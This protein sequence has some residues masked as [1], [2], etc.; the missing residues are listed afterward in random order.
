MS[1]LVEQLADEATMRTQLVA[2]MEHAIHGRYFNALLETN[3]PAAPV[4]DARTRGETEMTSKATFKIDPA[5]LAVLQRSTIT[6]TTVVL[7]EG[8]LDRKLYIAVNKVLEASGGKWM[9]GPKHHAFPSD[10]RKALGLALETGEAVDEQKLFQA[11]YTPPAV[12]QRVVELA[13]LE[14]GNR[15]L[16]PSAGEGALLDAIEWDRLPRGVG[17]ERIWN[18]RSSCAVEM[19]PKAAAVLRTKGY[20]VI[21]ADFLQTKL[22][23]TIGDGAVMDFSIDWRFDRILMNPPFTGGQDVGHV[24]H[25]LKFLKPGGILVSVM[26]AGVGFKTDKKTIAFNKLLDGIDLSW[27]R[28]ECPEGAF[29]ESGTNVRVVIVK[30]QKAVK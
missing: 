7:P 17:R 24:T 9:K 15:I 25:A 1:P 3:K 13:E 11:F 16:E 19:N 4:L 29:T 23:Q 8:Q 21:E 26:S 10:P 18:P 14:P 2:L 6:E 30:V 22:E 28:E 5:V 20:R 12:A 27:S